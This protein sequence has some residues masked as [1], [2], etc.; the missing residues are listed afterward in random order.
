[1]AFDPVGYRTGYLEPKARLKLVELPDDLF[2]RYAIVLPMDEPAIAARLR[3]VRNAWSNQTNG[4]RAASYARR[5]AGEDER[6][7]AAY[8]DAMGTSAWWQAQADRQRAEASARTGQLRELLQETYAGFGVLTRSAVEECARSFALTEAEVRDA[9]TEVGLRV[10]RGDELP[11]DAPMGDEQYRPLIERMTAAGVPSVVHLVHPEVG[12]FHVLPGFRA[13]GMPAARLDGEAVGDQAVAAARLANGHAS[14]ARR[15][16]LDIVR[17]Y[18]ARGDVQALALWNLAEIA[19][20]WAGPGPVRMR[21]EL[22]RIGLVE[23]DAA[24]LAVLVAASS[25][26]SGA[27]GPDRIRTLLAD[28]RL[29]EAAQALGEVADR[30]EE[31]AGLVARVADARARY[32]ALVVE[33]RALAARGDEVAALRAVRE[34]GVISAQEAEEVRASIPLPPPLGLVVGAEG[35]TAHLRWQPNLGHGDDVVFVV[36]R[37][38]GSPVVSPVQGRVVPVDAADHAAEARLPVARPLVYSVFATAPGR[39]ASRPATTSIVLVPPVADLRADVG[40][41]SVAVRWTGHPDAVRH[42]AVRLVDGRREPLPVAGSGV[43]VTG[44]PE[45]APVTV[46]VIAEYRSPDGRA[47]RSAPERVTATPRRRAVPV[48]RLRARPAPTTEHG[49]VD[50]SWSRVDGSDV[51]IRRSE[52]PAPWAAGTWIDAAEFERFGAELTG[53]RSLRGREQTLHAT[54]PEGRMHHLTAFSAG[55]TGIVVGGRTA[56]G[57]SA[58]VLDL[59]AVEFARFAKLTWTWPPGATRVEVT[60]ERDGGDDDAAGVRALK[61]SEYDREG[62]FDVPTAGLATTV[63]VRALTA[64]ADGLFGSPAVA[65]RVGSA[66]A[67]RIAYRVTRRGLGPWPAKTVLV[68]FTSEHAARRVRIGVVLARGAVMPTSPAAGTVLADLVLDLAP[69]QPFTTEPLPLPKSLGRPNWVR[70]FADDEDV[71]LI[72]PPLTTLKEA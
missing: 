59:R 34:A 31:K 11:T 10:L 56:V 16:A 57:L 6:L 14:D 33:A 66:P 39:P 41:D 61:R 38:D 1:M 37:S 2:E 49:N 24:A 36:R 43:D 35:S 68:H 9:A 53:Q 25:T 52:G 64:G 71:E 12:R 44:L 30:F 62:G 32:E 46:E 54:V 65:L 50:V 8:G 42:D 15:R 22:I 4:T 17:L 47:L 40:A 20:Q 27:L 18:S 60:W 29:L 63:S 69:G 26:D 55:G 51:R 70:C 48:E 58:A 7:R 67:A 3:D 5:C 72:D 23:E 13:E 19:R 28:G 21:Q 45:G